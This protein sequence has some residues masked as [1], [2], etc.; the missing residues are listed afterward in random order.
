MEEP[1]LILTCSRIFQSA[2]SRVRGGGK[3]TNKRQSKTMKRITNMF[4][5][6][7]AQT[8][9]QTK[10]QGKQRALST[11][12]MSGQ[13][14]SHNTT[15][16]DEVLASFKL[17]GIPDLAV[18]SLNE[19]VQPEVEQSTDTMAPTSDSLGDPSDGKADGRYESDLVSSLF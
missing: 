4:G 15:W 12:K 14:I 10:K 1:I 7:K 9:F 16:A 19:S 5:E 3:A 13:Q 11:A 8:E 2:R 18:S 17:C 6:R